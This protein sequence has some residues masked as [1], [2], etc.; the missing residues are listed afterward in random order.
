MTSSDQ[1]ERP[2]KQNVLITGAAGLV[3]QN[4]IASLMKS[5]QYTLVGVDKHTK[6]LSILQSSHPNLTLVNADLSEAGL[7][8]T[9]AKEADIIVLLHAQIGG[10]NPEE[11]E[12]NNVTATKR[13]LDAGT[14]GACNYLVHVSSSVVNSAA[15]DLYTESKKAQ[16]ELV[17]KYAIPKVILRPTLM[18]G[19]FD[20]KHVGWLHRFLH[21]VPIF[22]IPGNG[23]FLR[24]P[25][26]AGDFSSI[27]QS[28]LNTS[29]K[30]SYNISGRERID[31]IDMIKLLKRVTSA[32]SV[33]VKIPYAVF[34]MLLTIYAIFDRNPPF[35]TSQL[36]ALTTPDIFEVIDWPKIFNITATPLEEAFEKTFLDPK[37][38]KVVLEF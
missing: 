13:V 12:E 20:R 28:C 10:L 25:L 6:N 31:Y 18:F 16:E 37:Y 9:Y 34:H 1:T 30:G 36:K 21:K 5:N 35:T 7:W 38:S 8:E 4:L 33:I 19:W 26:Y 14:V 22:P 23:K 3:G 11:F 29:I 2:R 24:Q 32:S 27:I 15:V 17:S